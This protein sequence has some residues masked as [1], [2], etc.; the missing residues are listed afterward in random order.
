MMDR[1]WKTCPECG[2]YGSLDVGRS[3]VFCERCDGSG[4]VPIDDE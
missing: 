3:I 4:E 2:G 1:N